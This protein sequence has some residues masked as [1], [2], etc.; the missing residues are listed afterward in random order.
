MDCFAEITFSTVVRLIPGEEN[1]MDTLQWLQ[2]SIAMQRELG[3]YLC[4]TD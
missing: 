2:E 1:N 4:Y 3:T